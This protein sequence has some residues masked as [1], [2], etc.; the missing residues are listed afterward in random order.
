MSLLLNY[1]LGRNVTK[2]PET[3]RGEMVLDFATI[4]C[5]PFSSWQRQLLCCARRNDRHV[6]A[7]KAS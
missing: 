2:R 5:V 1:S 3:W 4:L 6:H 7:S